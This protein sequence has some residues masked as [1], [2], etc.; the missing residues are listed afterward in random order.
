MRLSHRPDRRTATRRRTARRCTAGSTGHGRLRRED[1]AEARP[2]RR[3][4]T[5]LVHAEGA[6]ERVKSRTVISFTRRKQRLARAAAA[7]PAARSWRAACARRCAF[8][9]GRARRTTAS[10]ARSPAARA[11]AGSWPRP[12]S[13]SVRGG[14]RTRIRPSFTCRCAKP[15]LP[16]PRVL[17]P[18]PSNPSSMSRTS[19]ATSIS[20]TSRCSATC[21]EGPSGPALLHRRPARDGEVAAEHLPGMDTFEPARRGYDYFSRSTA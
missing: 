9:S 14:N 20:R 2:S 5:L 3:T 17:I 21:W 15:G 6:G 7:R 18:I 1:R 13:A 4:K 11:P 10:S 19:P 12:N 16:A 8:P